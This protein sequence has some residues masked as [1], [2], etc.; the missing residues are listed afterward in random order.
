MINLRSAV[1]F[2]PCETWLVLTDLVLMF[3]NLCNFNLLNELADLTPDTT[4]K[5]YLDFFHACFCVARDVS[6]S[7]VVNSLHTSKLARALEHAE[8]SIGRFDGSVKSNHT[9]DLKKLTDSI[10]CKAI[11]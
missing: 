3:T 6:I 11:L 2:L 4:L 9:C 10:R 7:F 1:G 8:D 5:T